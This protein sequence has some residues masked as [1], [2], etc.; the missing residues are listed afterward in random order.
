MSRPSLAFFSSVRKPPSSLYQQDDDDDEF[1]IISTGVLPP[2]PPPQQQQQAVKKHKAISYAGIPEE[3][4]ESLSTYDKNE[5]SSAPLEKRISVLSARLNRSREKVQQ[6]MDVPFDLRTATV[7]DSLL[8]DDVGT[9]ARDYERHLTYKGSQREPIEE[10]PKKWDPYEDEHVGGGGGD[11]DEDEEEQEDEFDPMDIDNDPI[12][13]DEIDPVLIAPGMRVPDDASHKEIR[14]FEEY[15]GVNRANKQFENNMRNLRGP[16]QSMFVQVRN[17][18]A[19]YAKVSTTLDAKLSFQQITRYAIQRGLALPDLPV[20][21]KA[22]IQ[23]GLQSPNHEIGERPCIYALNNQCQSYLMSV[24][25]KKN[26]PK[27]YEGVEPFA[28]KV[29]THTE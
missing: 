19:I 5:R 2:P 16:E 25:A 10:E 17:E 20:V 7:D 12:F 3:Q 13:R 29:C 26:N 28:C 11:G 18:D 22:V 9:V 24:Q 21:S 6:T 27:K 8:M 1:E 4:L 14:T 15:V 23:D